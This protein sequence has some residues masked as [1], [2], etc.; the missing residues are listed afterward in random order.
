MKRYNLRNKDDIKMHNIL[1]ATTSNRDYEMSRLILL[2]DMPDTKAEYVLAEG[3]HC[4]CF[5]FDET[6]W[7]C[8]EL[9]E[10]ELRKILRNERNN[11]SLRGQL[12][13]FLD[14]Y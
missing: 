6:E 5:D 7:D 10:N 12:K 3:Y 11:R 4:S 14:I 9:T 2:E 13:E 1:F 8:V